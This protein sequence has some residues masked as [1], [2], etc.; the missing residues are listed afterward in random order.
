MLDHIDDQGILKEAAAMPGILGL[1]IE[2][3]V[4]EAL[5]VDKGNA[6]MYPDEEFA[7]K[8]KSSKTGEK[9]RHYP[10]SDAAN[11]LLSTVSFLLRG[12]KIPDEARRRTA[13]RLA[14]RLDELGYSDQ[15][16]VLAEYGGSAPA[17]DVEDTEEFKPKAPKP[18]P[19]AKFRLKGQEVPVNS[20]Q[21]IEAIASDID[22]D[23]HLLSPIDRRCAALQI[24]A[25][26]GTPPPR[27]APYAG[28]EKNAS[29]HQHMGDRHRMVR[30]E[31]KGLALSKIGD[32]AKIADLE[33]RVAAVARFDAEFG[34]FAQLPDAVLSVVSLAKVAAA[35]PKKAE[36]PE[37]I[38][39]KV[40]MLLGDDVPDLLRSGADIEP[41]AMA[42]VKRL[43]KEARR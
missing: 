26:G 1:D 7:L 17:K 13:A 10:M 31:D 11:T 25:L 43:M 15:A 5:P 14:K 24:V 12:N 8:V 28:V 39:P 42:I 20:K 32:I 18:E 40:A 29:L 23:M 2:K 35:P 3:L 34:P 22:A 36:Y 30:D 27:L 38:M 9:S 37:E 41:E 16:R 4:A 33:A 6:T 21:D 19:K